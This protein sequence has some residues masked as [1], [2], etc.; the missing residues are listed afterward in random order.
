MMTTV[1]ENNNDNRRKEVIEKKMDK[2]SKQTVEN[3]IKDGDNL[4]KELFPDIDNW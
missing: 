1:T 3:I 2:I 4:L